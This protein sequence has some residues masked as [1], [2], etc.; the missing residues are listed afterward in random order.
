LPITPILC[1]LM[2]TCAVHGNNN[3]KA[4][5]DNITQMR[6]HTAALDDTASP[7]PRGY[8]LGPGALAGVVSNAGFAQRSSA[9]TS[10]RTCALWARV[11]GR[12]GQTDAGWPKKVS[13]RVQEAASDD[14]AHPGPRGDCLVPRALAGVVPNAGFAQRSSAGTLPRTCA[15]WARVSGGPGQTD[16]GWPKKVSRRVQAAALDDTAH[17]SGSSPVS[18]R[19]RGGSH[20]QS[21][22]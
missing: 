7:G 22:G 15:L 21:H 2:I 19:C 6:L 3:C 8:C 17:P 9:G 4:F 18:L 13:R 20:G 1:H 16:A 12:P 10:P 5:R 11:S 14:T